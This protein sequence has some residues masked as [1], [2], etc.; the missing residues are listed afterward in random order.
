MG[1]TCSHGMREQFPDPFDF[2]SIPVTFPAI[3]EF[4]AHASA[5]SDV[6]NNLLI[7]YVGG[8]DLLTN[9]DLADMCVATLEGKLLDPHSAVNDQ[10]V[11]MSHLQI[12]HRV[13][14]GMPTHQMEGCLHAFM[15]GHG[16]TSAEVEDMD[17]ETAMHIAEHNAELEGIRHSEER[18]PN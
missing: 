9:D 13:L 17:E 2:F 15:T 18:P 7:S 5:G 1:A 16:S 4:G 11:N 12:C 6:V 14:G 3:G 10:V 8:D